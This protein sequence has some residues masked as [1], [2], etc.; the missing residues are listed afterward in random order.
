MPRSKRL[1]LAEFVTQLVDCGTDVIVQRMGL[2]REEADALALAITREFCFRNAKCNVYVPDQA[3][4]G[5][6]ERNA[7][8]WAEYQQDGPA[9][10]HAKK[11][12]TARLHELAERYDLTPQHMYIVLAEQRALELSERQPELPGLAPDSAAEI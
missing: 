2:P 5:R 4:L 9:P 12:T 10:R 11:F 3:N 6:F 7:L 1:R 8:I